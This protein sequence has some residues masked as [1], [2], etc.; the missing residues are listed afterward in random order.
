MDR[1]KSEGI[2]RA[3][4]LWTT[5]LTMQAH[6]GAF[7]AEEAINVP[8]AS[9]PAALAE[10]F[11]LAAE[12]A[13][14]SIVTIE[15]YGGPRETREWARRIAQ[16]QDV[17]PYSLK[18]QEVGPTGAR[19]GVGTGI[20]FDARG[21]V[22]TCHHV[23]S[24]AD[25]AFVVFQDGRRCEVVKTLTDPF[26]DVAVLQIERVPQLRPAEL[27]NASSLNNGD[28]VIAIGNPYGLGVSLTAGIVSAKDRHLD[29]MP[30]TGLI[31]TDAAT[32]PGNSGGALIDL[33]GR[34]VGVSEGSYGVVEGFQGI[35]F[36]IPIEIA[37][38]V[39][40]ELIEKGSVNRPFL[41]LE[42][43]DISEHIA[44]HIGLNGGKGVIV[45]DVAARSPAAQAGVAVGDVIVKVN[46]ERVEKQL[47]FS[48]LVTDA[49]VDVQL[50]LRLVR[51]GK[52]VDVAI[53]PTTSPLLSNVPQPANG[54][55][56]SPGFFDEAL[57]IVVDSAPPE[58]ARD[59]GYQAPIDGLLIKNVV[60]RSLAAKEGICAGM[61]LLRLDGE[62]V[63]TLAD[64]Q[65]AVRH[66]NLAGGTLLL[67]GTP[68]RR[69]FVLCK[70]VGNDFET[71]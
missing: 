12:K 60:A 51:E 64:Y 55:E 62:I 3:V 18:Q 66:R 13:G 30:Y 56:S 29:R 33:D 61:S 26:T 42:T 37:S 24:E 69:H 22:M 40:R 54:E 41:G 28:W 49:S 23:I 36:A 44:R 14:P 17:D 70:G 46:G 16:S 43:E 38:K 65:A 8:H 68:Q 4:F 15:T 11:R 5:A 63:K 19:D 57:G 21:Y 10:A 7:A 45:S 53:S 34:I 71:P 35:G 9:R 48:R 59:L 47:D 31:Q 67:I 39:A 52:E 27:G 58:V 2:R 32:N 50:S 6:C 20:V 1:L 25:M